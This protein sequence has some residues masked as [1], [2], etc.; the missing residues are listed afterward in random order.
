MVILWLR[1]KVSLRSQLKNLTGWRLRAKRCGFL[2]MCR[3][4]RP[5]LEY[6]RTN[7]L[8]RSA[9]KTIKMK[10]LVRSG[11]LVLIWF[12]G[13][14]FAENTVQEQSVIAGIDPATEVRLGTLFRDNLIKK[15]H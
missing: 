6:E 4:L 5:S 2:S 12:I 9:R 3:F 10:I 7:T 15:Y 1:K 13:Q 14:S 11:V 8:R